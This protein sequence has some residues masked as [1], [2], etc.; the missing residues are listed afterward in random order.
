MKRQMTFK[1]WRAQLGESLPLYDAAVALGVEPAELC[2]AAAGRRL[3]VHRFDAA[4]GRAYYLVR[5]DDLLA[6][7]RGNARRK[8]GLSPEGMRRAFARMAAA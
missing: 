6:Y 2:R 4:D 5:V 1:Q 7:A 3:R 8:Q